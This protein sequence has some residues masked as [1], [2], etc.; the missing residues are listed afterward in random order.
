MVRLDVWPL[1]A[2]TPGPLVSKST[3]AQSRSAIGRPAHDF[4]RIVFEAEERKAEDDADD[5][6]IGGHF[7]N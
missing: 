5:E 1:K 4:R 3:L 7:V 2:P 6:L